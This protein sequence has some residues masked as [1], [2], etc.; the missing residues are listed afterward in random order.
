MVVLSG[1]EWDRINQQL[2][3]RQIE[4]ER[5]KSIREEKEARKALSKDMVKDWPNTLEVSK[6]TDILC[7]LINHK[8]L[9][10]HQFLHNY[11]K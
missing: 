10:N 7:I 6:S 4:Q 3:R 11:H 2:Y 9:T 8:L 1:K 5:I